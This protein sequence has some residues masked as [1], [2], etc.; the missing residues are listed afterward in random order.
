[1]SE[2]FAP[3]PASG[4]EV[5]TVS[6]AEGTQCA[7]LLPY[8]VLISLYAKE[9]PEYLRES[10]DSVFAQTVP[11]EQIVIVKDGPLSPQLDSM[12]EDYSHQ[13]PELFTFVSYPENHGL[14][15][16]LGQGIPACRNEL[17]MRMDVDD[18]SAPTRAEEQ[19]ATYAEHPELGCVGT[20][21]VEFVGSTDNPVAFVD[22]P[23]RHEDIIRYGRRRCPYRHPALM[24]RKSAV[25]RAGGYQRMPMF[26]DYD[27]YMRLA[28]S[29][30]RFYNIQR[31]LVY[32]RTSPEFYARRGGVEYTRDMMRFEGECLRRGDINLGEYLTTAIPHAAVCLMPNS[33]RSFVY[34]RFLRKPASSAREVA[35]G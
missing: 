9:R 20:V 7:D 8:S 26:E 13:H 5:E 28:S 18:W 15:Y 21:V 29:G 24:Y 34:S 2:D 14:W 19:L 10:M 12:L 1:M 17:V 16:A 27:L 3:F 35:Q 33:L 31:P 25:E 6:A 22:L 4:A 30:C 32:M 23:E 11:P